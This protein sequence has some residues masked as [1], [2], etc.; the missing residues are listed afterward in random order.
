MLLT[1]KGL[2]YNRSLDMLVV[3]LKQ[4]GWALPKEMRQR[5][6]QMKHN[7]MRLHQ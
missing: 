6:T 1:R 5:G 3:P 4:I 2:K 7:Y